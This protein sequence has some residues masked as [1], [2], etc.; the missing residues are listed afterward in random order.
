MPKAVVESDNPDEELP[1]VA[2]KQDRAA[3]SLG[4]VFSWKV[5][6]SGLPL[7]P[8]GRLLAPMVEH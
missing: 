1:E 5:R 8:L 4:Q 2:S 7:L 3:Q 6:C